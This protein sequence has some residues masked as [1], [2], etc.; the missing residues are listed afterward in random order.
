MGSS[1]Q[2]QMTLNKLMASLRQSA[3]TTPTAKVPSRALSWLL[4][5]LLAHETVET[6]EDRTLTVVGG[7][8]EEILQEKC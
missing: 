3:L 5:G 8:I 7:Y 6:S 2:Y 1:E 4:A